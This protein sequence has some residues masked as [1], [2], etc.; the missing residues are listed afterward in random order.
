MVRRMMTSAARTSP[1]RGSR[2]RTVAVLPVR[3]WI[4]NG[5]EA[6]PIGRG[7]KTTA[8]SRPGLQLGRA[9]GTRQ[10]L[11]SRHLCSCLA[12]SAG[13]LPPAPRPDCQAFRLLHSTAASANSPV[14][15]APAERYRFV[16][17]AENW[18]DR[19]NHIGRF[20]KAKA[21]NPPLPKPRRSRSSRGSNRHCGTGSR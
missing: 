8:V 15:L 11:A 19:A 6:M 7:Q 5:R 17:T 14:R 16:P 2:R 13:T 4:Q 1:L 9:E 10:A 21:T 18:S 12:P 20:P 3:L